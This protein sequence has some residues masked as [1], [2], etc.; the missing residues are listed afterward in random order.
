METPN[1]PKKEKG[2][3]NLL[4][5][6]WKCIWN[7]G[8]TIDKGPDSPKTPEQIRDEAREKCPWL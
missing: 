4:E 5:K 8:G 7:S 2:D 3:C 6:L 1:E